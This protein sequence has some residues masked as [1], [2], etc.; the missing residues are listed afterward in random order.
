[1]VQV[2]LSEELQTVI[3]QMPGIVVV[4]IY[5]EYSLLSGWTQLT[6][7]YLVYGYEALHYF[8]NNNNIYI[9]LV[10]I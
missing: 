2:T 4:S 10:L 5:M 9:S 6:Y 3:F 7:Y 8:C 1:M